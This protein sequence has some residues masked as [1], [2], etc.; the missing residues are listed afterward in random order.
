MTEDES[1][2]FMRDSCMVA[3]PSVR[4][5]VMKNAKDYEKTVRMW[6]LALG[7]LTRAECDEVVRDWVSGKVDRPDT[8][9]RE[10]RIAVMIREV[11]LKRRH[12]AAQRH[13]RSVARAEAAYSA[14]TGAKGMAEV[15]QALN[16]LRERLT[17]KDISQQEF[18]T[19]QKEL[20]NEIGK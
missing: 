14:K 13:A 11:V 20:L 15:F 19:R 6:C 18:E 4:A 8:D 17:A 12:E 1:F 3:F 9:W 10:E 7:D 16:G 2:A 5:W